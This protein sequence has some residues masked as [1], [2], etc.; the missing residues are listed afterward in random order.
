MLLD[1]RQTDV[2]A[3]APRFPHRGGEN[4]SGTSVTLPEGEWTDRLTGNVHGGGTVRIGTLLDGFPVALLVKDSDRTAE[5][6]V[7]KGQRRDLSA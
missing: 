4:W 7:R 6:D 1:Q 3:V 2:I 5:V